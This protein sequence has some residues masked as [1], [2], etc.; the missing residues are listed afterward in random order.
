[1]THAY[2]FP[3]SFPGSQPVSFVRNHL[4]ALEEEDY[5]VCEKSDGTRY[6]LF[7]ITLP[8]GPAVFLIDRKFTVRYVR[9]LVLIVP[10]LKPNENV[11]THHETL[12]DGELV[13]R[14]DANGK[15]RSVQTVYY[16]TVCHGCDIVCFAECSVGV[17]VRL[18]FN[19]ALAPMEISCL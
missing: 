11:K 5:W 10:P 15:V 9:D 7:A 8:A 12:L 19:V 16:C 2:L 1:M 3:F 6:L 18:T 4:K 13:E 17:L 14:G